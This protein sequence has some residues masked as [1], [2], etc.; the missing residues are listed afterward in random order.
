M[1]TRPSRHAWKAVGTLSPTISW[2]AAGCAGVVVAACGAGSNTKLKG[3]PTADAGAGNPAPAPSTTMDAGGGADASSSFDAYAVF[4]TTIEPILDTAG[5]MGCTNSSCHGAAAGIGGLTL[6][7]TPAAGSPQ[8][9]ANF[10]AITALCNPQVPDQSLFYIQATNDHGG[11][12]VSQAQG[13]EI[14]DWIQHS[15]SPSSSTGDA[16]PSSEAGSGG[17]GS[18]PPGSPGADLTAYF[19]LDYFAGEIQP[20]LFGTV[21]YNEAP[22]QP[23]SSDSCGRSSCHGSSTNPLSLS[24]SNSP[25]TNLHNF[26]CFVNLASPS[27]SPILECP[28]NTSGCTV[29]TGHPGQNVFSSEQDLNFQRIASWLYSAQPP[30]SAP[31]GTQGAASPLDFAWFARQVNPTFDTPGAGG[32]TSGTCSN[33]STCHG[34]TSAGQSPPNLSN[35]P[36]L[37]N[38]TTKQAFLVNY[39]V[40]AGFANFYTPAGSELFLYPTNEV[41]DATQPYATGLAHPGGLDFAVGSAPANQILTW[42]TGLRPDA[43]GD[44]LD[45]LVAGTYDVTEITDSTAAGAEAALAPTIFDPSNTDDNGGIWDVCASPNEL[46]DLTLSFGASG[47]NRV[48]YA[49]ANVINTAGTPIQALVTVTSPNAIEAWVGTSLGLGEQPAPA[50]NTAS[51]SAIFP[52]FTTAK[53]TTRIL[54]KILQRPGDTQ[55]AFTVNLT[56][57]TTNAPLTDSTGELVFRLDPTGGI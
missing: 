28:L 16:G 13:T 57:L 3:S 6:T 36:I 1:H 20:I 14:L 53:T 9:Q 35:F 47:S 43:N 32:T 33:T 21:N 23:V 15:G 45:W 11:I 37:A 19:N 24:P 5:G 46:V 8:M 40:A 7:R 2:L 12:A 51:I 54:V 27:A 42:A 25:A 30:S 31:A 52:P 38:A 22:G 17:S 41:A 39:A 55:F 18:C 29:P 34:V 50:T 4:Q 26:G 49:Y 44:M 48:A 56:N 10:T